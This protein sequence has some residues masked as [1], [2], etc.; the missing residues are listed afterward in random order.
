MI[1]LSEL[2]ESQVDA[3]LPLCAIFPGTK[4][5]RLVQRPFGALV[6]AVQKGEGSTCHRGD[7]PCT[8]ACIFRHDASAVLR[9]R[10]ICS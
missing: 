5:Y 6:K 2:F 9:A 7:L 3:I 8:R 10:R 4:G 1:D